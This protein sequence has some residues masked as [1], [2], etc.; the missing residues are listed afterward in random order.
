MALIGTMSDAELV[1]ACLGGNRSAFEQIVERYQ[2]LLC[3]LAYSA[4]GDLAESEDVAQ[5][6]FVTAWTKLGELREPEK[7]KAWL[8]SI[9][10]FKVSH[11]RR[12]RGRQPVS[13]A[14]ELYEAEAVET[15]EVEAND[16]AMAKEEQ[17]IL[18]HALAQL[19]DNYRE[20]LV[21]YYREHRSIEHVAVELDLNEDTVKQRLS[22]GRKMLKEQ[23]LA[24]V[25]GAL[26]RSAPGKL[27][28]AAVIAALP[29]LVPTTA[30]AA[31]VGAAAAA[32]AKGAGGMAKTTLLAVWLAS[33]SGFIS[34]VM[35]LRMNLDQSRTAR[36]RRQVVRMTVLLLGSFLGFIA[37]VFGWGMAL[38]RL[39]QH[40]GWAVPALHL[41]IV[42]FAIGW[43]WLIIHLMRQQRA[44]R[45][46]E[47]QRDEAAF[48]DPRDQVGSA[49]SE[50][51][52]RARF[53]GVPLVHIRFAAADAGQPPTF[54][55]IAG[56]DRAIG[57]LFAWGGWAVGFFS[58]G[59]VAVGVV[60]FGAVSVGL[61]SL[62]ALAFG[63]V[64]LGS[65]S[66]GYHAVA[67]LAAS[68][69]HA[70]QS[71]LLAISQHVAMGKVAIATHAN[72]E[73]AQVALANPHAQRDT[74]I[75]CI[76]MVVLALVPTAAYAKAVRQRM[77]LK[78]N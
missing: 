62:G 74:L 71:P 76:V 28:T 58:G 45:A 77:K 7:L 13:G 65:V 44:L 59:A 73:V 75:F 49:A 16:A 20:P 40:Q 34:S 9:L 30:K 14:A 60:S 6:T 53:L 18:W 57:L 64:A 25:E 67:S 70:A 56:G 33:V 11:A 52:S 24:F 46:S 36:E 63:G 19:P 55:W 47:R 42:G 61:I 72:D 15:G 17:A 12:S 26:S 68:A 23:A 66:V 31:G 27:F 78:Q 41:F 38:G 1:A 69:W 10:R 8:C 22:R 2:R 51:K 37:V 3:S 5:E 32:A 35:T 50:Y 39:P 43:S 4:M 48:Q 29:A 21:L 54:G